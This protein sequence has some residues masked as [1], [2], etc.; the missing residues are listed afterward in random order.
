MAGSS[1]G[2]IFTVTTR[3]EPVGNGIGVVIDGVPA[4]IKLNE[5]DVQSYLNRRKPFKA[6]FEP[7]KHENDFVSINSGISNGVTNGL[8]IAMTITNSS[9]RNKKDDSN[10]RVFRPGQDDFTYDA[11]FGVRSNRGTGNAAWRE[12]AARVAAGA[13]AQAILSGIGISFCSYVSSI[14]PVS[15]KYASSSVENISTN[16]LRMPD[17]DAAAEALAY[18]EKVAADRD[19]AGGTVEVVVTGVPAGIG[20]PVF[21][22]LDARLAQAVMSIGL[23][24]GVEFGEGFGATLSTGT[25]TADSFSFAGGRV[26]KKSNSSGG[27][28]G[29]ISDGSEIVLRASVMP[30]PVTGITTK[31]VDNEGNEVDY[32]GTPAE[33]TI[34]PRAVVVVESMMAI[35]LVDMLFE[36]M[37]S[38]IDSIEDYYKAKR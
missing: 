29:G 36:N 13:V 26:E 37:L 2:K 21:N 38:K 28:L 33:T 15:I 24:N 3:G 35:A 34:V 5:N 23:I 27:M 1:F 14:G 20:E 32:T 7:V 22:K 8:P 6:S 10:D 30:T 16:P 12:T 11:K 31:T 17:R 25:H 19:S 9:V 18:L 4:G